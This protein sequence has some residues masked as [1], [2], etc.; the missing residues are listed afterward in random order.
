[1]AENDN[2]FI[3]SR[4]INLDEDHTLLQFIAPG[5]NLIKS[6]QYENKDLTD[7]AIDQELKKFQ[8]ESSGHIIDWQNALKSKDKKLQNRYP[9]QDVL[10]TCWMVNRAMEE[11]IQSVAKEQTVAD[12]K[13]GNEDVDVRPVD[14]EEPKD[15]DTK[16][17]QKSSDSDKKTE[18]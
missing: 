18:K 1:M 6:I 10:D 8:V 16:E 5:F 13:N 9:N 14:V 3:I 15:D 17:S 7:E 4:G 11:A 2:F 12:L